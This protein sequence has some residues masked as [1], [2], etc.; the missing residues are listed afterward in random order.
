MKT[1]R[2]ILDVP[3]KS[4]VVA[5]QPRCVPRRPNG[6]APGEVEIFWQ[7]DLGELAYHTADG[8]AWHDWGEQSVPQ[9]IKMLNLFKRLMVR[10][11]GIAIESVEAAYSKI[12][13]YRQWRDGS[14]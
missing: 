6:A 9:L 5:W 3:I 11:H 12:P 2:S 1:Q 10:T 13:E 4:A 7:G 8:A 14:R